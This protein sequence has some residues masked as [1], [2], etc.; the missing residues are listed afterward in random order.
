MLPETVLKTFWE[1]YIDYFNG[2][3]GSF[4]LY[5]FAVKKFDN[6]IYLTTYS[7]S[8]VQAIPDADNFNFDVP[9]IEDQ[10]RIKELDS[11]GKFKYS[12]LCGKCKNLSAT[13]R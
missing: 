7:D 5:N 12:R 8:F 4:E 1:Q 9:V 6:K 11:I 3:S 13:V 10:V 2:Q